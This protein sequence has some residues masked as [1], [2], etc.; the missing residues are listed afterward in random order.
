P[1][2]PSPIQGEGS[3]STLTPSPSPIQG[4]GSWSTLT[5][6]PSPI[7]GEGSWSTL[8]PSP[9]P[10]QGEGSE[11]ATIV[12]DM[13]PRSPCGRRGQRVRANTASGRAGDAQSHRPNSFR[14]RVLPAT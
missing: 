14:W 3:W 1:S 12:V 4:E 7:Q 2:R 13:L 9:S 6:S 8:T 5:P 10:I 11:L